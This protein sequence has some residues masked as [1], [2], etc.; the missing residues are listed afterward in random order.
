[1]SVKKGEEMDWIVLAAPCMVNLSFQ[2]LT[3]PKPKDGTDLRGFV[4]LLRG[5][6]L[7]VCYDTQID[8]CYEVFIFWLNIYHLF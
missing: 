1:M 2:V 7:N 4:E 6:L 8:A 5:Q 3:L